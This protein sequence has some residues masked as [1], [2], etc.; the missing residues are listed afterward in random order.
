MANFVLV[1]LIIISSFLGF[2][3]IVVRIVEC[4]Y[5]IIITGLSL[6]GR[7]ILSKFL[8]DWSISTH[9]FIANIFGVHFLYYYF[10]Y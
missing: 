10:D 9:L 4:I 6:I 3:V 8:L 1:D 5:P 2:A 7:A